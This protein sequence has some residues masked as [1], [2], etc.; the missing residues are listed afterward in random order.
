ME[1]S[2]ENISLYDKTNIID[3]RDKYSYDKKHFQGSRNISYTM[4]LLYPQEYLKKEQ[5]YILICE[6]GLKSKEVSTILN[7]MGY[8]TFS[9]NGG[10][11]AYRYIQKNNY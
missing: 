8:K 1:I 5:E 4:L 3:L 9:V 2:W 6:Y 11:Q 7:K 10:M